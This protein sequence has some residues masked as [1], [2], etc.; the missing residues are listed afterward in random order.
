MNCW[1]RPLCFRTSSALALLWLTSPGP[2]HAE[3]ASL[4]ETLET[5][6]ADA[7]AAYVSPISSAFGANLNSGWFRSAPGA[8]K[9]GF[10]LELGMVVMGSFFPKD[11]NHFS[12][13]GQFRLSE[14][15]AGFLLDE[16]EAQQGFALPQAV[17]DEL[18]EQI[19]S[20]YS[21]VGI[22]GAT[23]VGASTDSL[24]IAF[25]GAVYEAFGQSYAVPEAA[26]KL[27]VGGFGDLADLPL[28]PLTVP[29]ISLGT[30]FGTQLTLRILPEVELNSELGKYRYTGFGLQHNPAVWL[31]HKLPVDLALSYFTQTMDVGTLFSCKANAFGITAS[32]RWGWRMLNLTPYAGLLLESA[33]MEVDYLLQVPV[34]VSALYPDGIYSEPIHIVLESANSSRLVLGCNLRAGIINWN[35]DYN[36]AEYGG[37]S[38]GVSLAF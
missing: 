3:E 36:L 11:A 25:P 32:K 28:L 2:V 9:I 24:T 10:N 15:E 22:S 34:P 23:V 16:F 12:V 21:N 18:T 31:D 33:E 17:R 27:P 26:V 29:Q 1:L 4:E 20:Q 13:D 19:T 8:K 14:S 5:L 6:S 38:T 7:A 30:V 37:F 35:L